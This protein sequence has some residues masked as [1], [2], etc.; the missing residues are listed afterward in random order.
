MNLIKEEQVKKIDPE[1]FRKEYDIAV[2]KIEKYMK[3]D[4]LAEVA[5]FLF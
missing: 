1:E 2:R 5:T 3:K 4:E